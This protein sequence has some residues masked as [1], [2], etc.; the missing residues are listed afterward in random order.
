MSAR[1]LGV[2]LLLGGALAQRATGIAAA[3]A[4]PAA[5]VIEARHDPAGRI[6]VEIATSDAALV[7]GGVTALVDGVPRTAKALP[8]TAPGRAG[9]EVSVPPLALGHHEVSLR[10]GKAAAPLTLA[11]GIEVVNEGLLRLA[12]AA[13]PDPTA[14]LDVRAEVEGATAGL[15][16]RFFLDG[17]PIALVRPSACDRRPMAPGTRHEAPR[18]ARDHR[19]AP[20][21]RDEHVGV[22]GR[23][24]PAANDRTRARRRIGCADAA[25]ERPGRRRAVDGGARQATSFC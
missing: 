16:V 9:L 14:V 5:S 18:G 23:A 21:G 20:R 15:D 8:S 7:A 22:G 11:T 25:R 1:I 10:L 6:V 13:P 3:Q 4:G 17:A 19:R 12:V 24:R 2:L